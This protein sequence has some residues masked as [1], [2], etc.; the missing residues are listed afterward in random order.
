MH[1]IDLGIA[2]KWAIALQQQVLSPGARCVDA[3]MGNG[4][5]TL[6]LCQAV[7]PTGRVWA[8][9]VQQQALS[10]TRQRLAQAGVEAELILDGHENV[11][12]YVQEPIHL[13]VFNLGWLPGAPHGTRT[14][15]KTTLMAVEACLS[16]L[17]PGGLM[18]LCV[19]P[20]HEEGKE[21]L[22]ALLDWA[23]QLDPAR[24]DATVQRYLNQQKDPPVLIAVASR[25]AKQGRSGYNTR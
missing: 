4:H 6:R 22:A 23:Q 5:D 11:A 1:N 24:Y 16:L 15:Q 12:Q 7:G 8:F 25:I 10:V 9:D 20:G 19:Y 3:T 18:T 2:S 14:R 17:L 21:E 13:A